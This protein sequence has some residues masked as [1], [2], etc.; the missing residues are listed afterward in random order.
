MSRGTGG[1]QDEAVAVTA[2]VALPL[3]TVIALAAALFMALL[4]GAGI[5]RDTKV[6]VSPVVPVAGNVTVALL[7]V[8]LVPVTTALMPLTVTSGCASWNE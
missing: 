1:L 6:A 8:G 5:V 4:A 7:V 2:A 3:V